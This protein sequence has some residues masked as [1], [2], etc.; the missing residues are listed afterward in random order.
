MQPLEASWGD[1]GRE[2]YQ[3]AFDAFTSATELD[4]EQGRNWLMVGYCAME[5]GKLADAK[6]ALQRAKQFPN[7]K[8]NANELLQRIHVATN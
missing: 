2:K 3:E 6:T 8:Q 4:P 1:S 5:T 7:Q